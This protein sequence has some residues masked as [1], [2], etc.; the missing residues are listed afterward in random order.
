M[1]DCGEHGAAADGDSLGSG[2]PFPVPWKLIP[3]N[4]YLIF[5]FI[6]S[7]MVAPEVA[8]KR[9]FLKSKGLKDPMNFM[10]LQRPDVPW[11]SQALTE[12]SLPLDFVPSNAMTTGPIVISV[13]SV[14]E[15]DPAMMRWLEQRPTVLISLGSSVEYTEEMSRIMV[16]AIKKVLDQTNVQFLWKRKPYTKYSDDFKAPVLDY[17]DQGRVRIETWLS[18]DPPSLLESGHITAFVH[19]GGANCYH[20][21]IACVQYHCHSH[22]WTG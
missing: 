21:A 7:V 15:Q 22:D 14:E 9:V 13:G 3:A 17:I 8:E 20:E 19:H 18:V 16:G 1:L 4:M 12:A 6:Y 2:F 5:R 10:E 11:I